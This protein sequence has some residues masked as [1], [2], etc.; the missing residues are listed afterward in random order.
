[1][2][3]LRVTNFGGLIPRAGERLLPDNAARVALNSK[4]L[5]GEIRSWWKPKELAS[6]STVA[7][8]AVFRFEHDGAEHFFESPFPAEVVKAP[9][10]N[11]K[12]K[13]LYWTSPLGAFVSPAADV[14]AG[15]APRPLGV[16]APDLAVWRGTVS[17]G[18][19]KQTETRVYVVTLVTAFGEEGPPS[20]PATVIGPSDGTWTITGL[21]TLTYDSATYSN[22]TKAR[23][24]RTITSAT[25][26]DYRRVDEFDITTRPA[27]YNDTKKATDIALTQPLESFNWAPPPDG[28]RGL[29]AVAGGFMAGYVGR[30]VYFSVPYRPHAWPE[31]FQYAV[32]DDIV[33]LGTYG[34]TVVIAT[35]GRPAFA[36]GSHPAAMTFA[37]VD[38]AYP[39]LSAD[40]LVSAAGAVLYPST[41][42]LV[43]VSDAGINVVT[44]GIATKDDWLR[45]YSPATIKAAV[46]DGRYIAMYTDQL[47]FVLG[48]SDAPAVFTELQ[49]EDVRLLRADPLTGRAYL[50]RKSKVYEWDGAT[51]DPLLYTWQSKPFILPKPQNFAAL[52]VR[53]N[54]PPPGAI[55]EPPAITPDPAS[56][57]P[58]NL[59]GLNT[60][61]FN[62]PINVRPEMELD[63]R[64][65]RGVYV[66]LYCEGVIRWR[67]YVY[68]E[69]PVRLPS[70][71]KGAHWKFEVQGALSIFSVA[72]STTAKELEGVQ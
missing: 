29:I 70:G 19:D 2:T 49:I 36:V 47:G 37:K 6:L 45:R 52:Q 46:T 10:I 65:Q 59:A 27:V 34:N 11:D 55:E 20:R 5:S 69:A 61:A 54:F 12:F 67:G 31:E 15:A 17:G 53:A 35:K 60:E 68:D 33:A 13:R 62:G 26:V 28:L 43:S 66:T 8:L 50:V 38:E 23:L 41:N 24:Y 44:S 3:V 25:G 42:G 58:L 30:T 56:P 72:L 1:M 32:E 4:L 64:L 48:F 18:D 51:D 7:P 63:P 16:P 22:V 71:F 21:D 57:Y 9:L 40:G 39:C 14:I